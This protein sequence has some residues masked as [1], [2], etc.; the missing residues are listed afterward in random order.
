MRDAFLKFGRFSKTRF[1]SENEKELAERLAS[2]VLLLHKLK[3][4]T[5]TVDVCLVEL[6]SFGG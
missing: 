6:I 1:A 2:F 5:C 3:Y 4:C